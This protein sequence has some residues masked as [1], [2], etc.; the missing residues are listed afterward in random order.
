VSDSPLATGVEV[1]AGGRIVYDIRSEID[2]STDSASSPRRGPRS[3]E[4]LTKLGRE[5]A[6]P[7]WIPAASELTNADYDKACSLTAAATP[8]SAVPNLTPK[9]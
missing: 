1:V 9:P 7:G 3:I 6:Q 2:I 8:D 5:I 4:D